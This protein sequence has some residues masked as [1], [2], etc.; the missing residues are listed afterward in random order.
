MPSPSDFHIG[1]HVA[2]VETSTDQL[3][4]GTVKKIVQEQNTW[5]IWVSFHPGA[6]YAEYVH[7]EGLHF[8][9]IKFLA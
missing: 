3:F 4:A 6:Q 5:S 8:I 1:Q 2:Y 9:T 7:G